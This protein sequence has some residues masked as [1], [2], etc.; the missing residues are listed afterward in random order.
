MGKKE[1][2]E[3]EQSD[4]DFDIS[5]MSEEERQRLLD[6]AAKIEEELGED[7]YLDNLEPPKELFDE[8]VKEAREQGLL[9]EEKE[10][11]FPLPGQTRRGQMGGYDCGDVGRRVWGYYDQSGEPSVYDG[12]SESDVWG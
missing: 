8:I 3:Y 2:K 11:D 7:P 9:K 12:E 5:K 4:A 1:N 10:E 6:E